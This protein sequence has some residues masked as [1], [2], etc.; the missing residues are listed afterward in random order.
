MPAEHRPLATRFAIDHGVAALS[1][2]SLAV[3]LLGYP[4]AA[5]ADVDHALENARE[6]RQAATLILAL[7]FAGADFYALPKP[8][9]GKRRSPRAY[10]DGRRKRGRY[11]KATG[12]ALRGTL[13]ALTGKILGCSSGD[14][15]GDQLTSLN[16][17]NYR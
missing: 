4:E 2:R 12:S 5:R 13:F 9:G 6:M 15:L 1:F 10:R 3:W 14:Q 7:S 8:H 11:W 16:W 17:S